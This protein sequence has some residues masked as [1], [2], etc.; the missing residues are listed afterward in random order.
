MRLD[1]LGQL[2]AISFAV[3]IL[4][5]ALFYTVWLRRQNYVL[6][7]SIRDQT[8]ISMHRD[9]GIDSNLFKF[10]AKIG[11]Y[12]FWQHTDVMVE[13]IGFEQTYYLVFYRKM[14]KFMLIMTPAIMSFVFLMAL[15]STKDEQVIVNRIIATRENITVKN[16][17]LTMAA[18]LYTVFMT[19]YLVKM[20]TMASVENLRVA[21]AT[22]NTKMSQKEHLWYELRTMKVY[23][24]S[25]LDTKGMHIRNVIEYFMLQKKIPGKVINVSLVPALHNTLRLV[26]QMESLNN[27]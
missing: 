26:S 10:M 11:W 25:P 22:E 14:I 2:L 24:I 23:G 21:L 16:D 19:W 20:R 6:P 9:P 17:S 12:I 8:R 7:P 15:Q 27:E 4:A 1:Y 5:L 13:E 18:C 3:I